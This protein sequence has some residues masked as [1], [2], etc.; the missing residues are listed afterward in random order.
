MKLAAIVVVGGAHDAG[1]HLL[2]SGGDYDHH[3]VHGSLALH[4]GVLNQT[5]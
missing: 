5:V 4:D 3:V 1:A 2:R